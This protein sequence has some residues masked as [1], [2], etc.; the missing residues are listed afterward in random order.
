MSV[1]PDT[2]GTS[3]LLSSRSVKSVEA[4]AVG[5]PEPSLAVSRITRSVAFAGGLPVKVPVAGLTASH[6][7]SASSGTTIANRCRAIAKRRRA[8]A[9]T[10]IVPNGARAPGSTARSIA[11][12]MK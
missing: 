5:W 6:G 12:S 11:A 7:G 1:A 2:V 10:M 9:M 4:V 8:M 3:L